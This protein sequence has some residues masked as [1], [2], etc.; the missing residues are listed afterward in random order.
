MA[1][2]LTSAGTAQPSS[3]TRGANWP[4]K[5]LLGAV[6]LVVLAAAALV[7]LLLPMLVIVVVSFGTGSALR[8]PPQEFSLARY[9]ELPALEGFKDSISLSLGVA[10]AT[11]TID[12]LPGVPASI[13]LARTQLPG[14]SVLIGFLQSPLMVPGIVVGISL[15]FFLSFIGVNVS[16]GLMTLSHVVITLPFVIRITYARMESANRTL[17]EAAEDLG[18]DR[19]QVFRQIILPHILPGIA[20]GSAFAF[21]LSFDNL[22]VSIFTAPVIDPPL[23]VYLFRLLLYDINPIVAPIATLQILI[24]FVVLGVASRTL[25][26]RGIIG[27]DRAAAPPNR[28]G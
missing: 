27:D 25:G 18:A 2:P 5:D 26:T 11:V 15:L 12:V 1:V 8:F 16:I 13:A 23:P 17:E 3:R 21:L 9:A 4:A 10:F 22:P 28:S 19:S 6:V 20:G 7:A 14:K 24:T